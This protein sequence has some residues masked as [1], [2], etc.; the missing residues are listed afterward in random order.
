MATRDG[1]T[2]VLGAMALA[3]RDHPRDANASA[4][5]F[6]ATTRFYKMRGQDVDCG[7]LTY[8]TW[9]VTSMPDFTG[10]LYTGTRC[11]ATPLANVVVEVAWT[12]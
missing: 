5:G 8:R 3:L 10:A 7:S 12:Q 6:A 4:Q 2:Y 1:N 11:G 9:I